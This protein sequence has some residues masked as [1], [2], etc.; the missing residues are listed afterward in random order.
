MLDERSVAE[1]NENGYLILRSFFSSEEINSLK[2]SWKD[3]KTSLQ[4]NSNPMIRRDRFLLGILPPLIGEIY[5]H[6]KLVRIG[7]QLLGTDLS[8]YFI[9]MLIKDAT[10]NGAVEPHQDIP[11]FHGSLDKLSVFIPLEKHDR[12]RGGLQ[13]VKN[14]HKYGNMGVRGTIQIQRFPHLEIESLDLEPGDICLMHMLTWHFSDPCE[15][16]CERPLIQL[17]YQKASDGSYHSTYL[18]KPTLVCG[19][20]KT[21]YFLDYEEGIVRDNVFIPPKNSFL[22]PEIKKLSWT[23]LAK[24]V[25]RKTGIKKLLLQTR[26]IL[27]LVKIKI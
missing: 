12:Q 9:R 15:I 18:S 3:L 21:K 20:W 26:L 25:A 2:N 5:L 6:S 11:Y 7:Q 23:S 10:F 4:S 17:I 24:A 22:I 27:D 13:L 16:L 14:S 19:Q 1:F 8:L